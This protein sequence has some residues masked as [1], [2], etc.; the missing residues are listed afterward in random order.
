MI[1]TRFEIKQLLSLQQEIAEM[2]IHKKISLA[3]KRKG[4]TQEQ[5]ADLTNITVR[6]IQRIEGGK[7]IPRAFTI[8]TIAAALDTPFEELTVESK[9]DPP[10][11]DLPI[12][13]NNPDP[14]NGR[15]FL[16][17]LCLSS[18]G[19]LVIPFVHFLVPVYLLKKSGIS[20][21]RIIAFGR[22]IIRQQIY[23]AVIFNLLLIL[24]L[25]Y[26]FMVVVYLNKTYLL[27]YLWIFFLMY[28]GNALLTAI[29]LRRI[30]T[31]DFTPILTT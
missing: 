5:L 9:N 15:H 12:T 1:L 31:I 29:N 20:D 25:A 28:I 22:S 18:F 16:K 10:L 27:H 7:S 19:Y 3:R 17:I 2:E 14:E 21:F 8:K 6:T 23:W 24:T 26:N 11:N 13:D 30:K 4:L